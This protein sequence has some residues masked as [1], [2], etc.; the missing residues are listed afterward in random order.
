MVFINSTPMSRGQPSRRVDEIDDV[1]VKWRNRKPA[2]LLRQPQAQDIAVTVARAPA[3]PQLR[4]H[5]P[6]GETILC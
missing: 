1:V 4:R 5:G 2:E 6:L 3:R